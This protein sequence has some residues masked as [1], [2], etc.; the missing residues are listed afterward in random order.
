MPGNS[1]IPT[2]TEPPP[3]SPGGEIETSMACK[4]GMNEADGEQMEFQSCKQRLEP[5]I[6]RVTGRGQVGGLGNAKLP[7]ICLILLLLGELTNQKMLMHPAHHEDPLKEELVAADCETPQ[8]VGKFKIDDETCKSAKENGRTINKTPTQQILVQKRSWVDIEAVS[9]F[10]R[11]TIERIQ[12]W[13]GFALDEERIVSPPIVEAVHQFSVAE[14]DRMAKSGQYKTENNQNFPLKLDA[15]NVFAY[16]SIGR[17]Y[18]REDG[19]SYCKGVDIFDDSNRLLRD[20]VETTS[21]R[22]IVKKVAIRFDLKKSQTGINQETKFGVPC[23]LSSGGCEGSTT[24]HWS[25]STDESFCD[26]VKVQSLHGYFTEGEAEGSLRFID[27]KAGILLQNV[28]EN[29]LH[30]QCSLQVRQSDLQGFLLVDPNQDLTSLKKFSADDYD[31]TQLVVERDNFLHFQLARMMNERENQRTEERC[32]AL[33]KI[34][35]T[36]FF[37]SG[38]QQTIFPTAQRGVFMRGKGELIEEFSCKVVSVL[39]RET[40]GCTVDLP[41]TYKNEA[42]YLQSTTRILFK[43]ST[44]QLC[45][46]AGAQEFETKS[47]HY[48]YALPSVQFIKILPS[49]LKFDKHQETDDFHQGLGLYTKEEQLKYSNHFIFERAK[50]IFQSQ[51]AIE[52]CMNQD[53]CGLYRFQDDGATIVQPTSQDPFTGSLHQIY[54]YIWS[55]IGPYLSTLNTLVLWIFVLYNY[56][57]AR[58][59]ASDQVSTKTELNLNLQPTSSGWR[60]KE[61]ADP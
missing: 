33:N 56:C 28:Q 2:S 27:E 19:N 10:A 26:L 5:G 38:D 34:H 50:K 15:E 49:K 55:L 12:C 51:T 25:S 53:R 13:D 59:A 31:I 54:G 48:I 47:G 23:S 8:H 4:E 11:K 39:P 42:Y 43:T 46:E 61:S 24:Y 37:N 30:K 35:R 40:G 14:C 18:Q 3:S 52:M 29:Q 16:N 44:P 7:S 32:E 36:N 45:S 20:V 58:S 21:I 1:T 41:V 57:K 9:C 22:I 17:I 60:T 6:G